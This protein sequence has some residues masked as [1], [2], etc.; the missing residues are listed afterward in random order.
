MK[1]GH[2]LDL[3]SQKSLAW[4]FHL[5]EHYGSSFSHHGFSLHSSSTQFLQFVTDSIYNLHE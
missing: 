2:M 4:E 5:A 1:Q 3:T